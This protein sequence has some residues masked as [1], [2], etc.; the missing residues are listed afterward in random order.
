MIRELDDLPRG[1]CNRGLPLK[2]SASPVS[3]PWPPML[4]EHTESVLAELC[5][6]PAVETQRMK[7]QGINRGKKTSQG[8]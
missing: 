5:G 3:I 6:V 2:L 7:M 4:G 1:K 8:D